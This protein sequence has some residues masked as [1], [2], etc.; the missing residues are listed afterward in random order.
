VQYDPQ[1]LRCFAEP[2]GGRWRA[3]CIDFSVEIDADSFDDARAKLRDAVLEE[4]DR[5]VEGAPPGATMA[6]VLHRPAPLPDRM[7]FYFL[8]KDRRFAVTN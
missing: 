5:V 8:A 1:T 2:K 4:V 6:E 7:K 3:V